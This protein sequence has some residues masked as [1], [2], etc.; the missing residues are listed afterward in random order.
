[1]M[2]RFC[3]VIFV[4]EIYQLA[5]KHCVPKGRLS[6][7]FP[8][9]SS[10]LFMLCTAFCKALGRAGSMS[11]VCIHFSTV[12]RSRFLGQNLATPRQKSNMMQ[13]ALESMD[14]LHGCQIVCLV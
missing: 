7:V 8:A 14:I 6:H 9:G 5:I 2:L 1:M 12:K 13:T 3:E 4:K 11:T 10:L